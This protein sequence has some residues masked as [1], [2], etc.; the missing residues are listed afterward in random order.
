MSDSSTRMPL[1]AARGTTLT[2]KSWLTEAPLRMLMNNLD[3]E[4]AERPRR[5]RRLRRH[6]QGGAQLGVLRRD[7]RGAAQR[8][9]ADETLLI[10]SGKPVGVFRT[11]ADAPRVLIANSNLVPRWATWEHFQRARPQGPHDVRPDDGRLVDLHRQPGHR[12]GHLRD[13]RRGGPP[14]LRRRPRRALDPHRRP[15]RHGRR[16]AAGRH[17]GR[18]LDARRSSAAER[19]DDAPADAATSTSQAHD[20]DDALAIIARARQDAGGDLGRP[21]RQRRRAAA[22]AACAAA[23]A[24]IWS[25]TRRRPTTRSTAICRRGWTLAQWD[26]H[27]PARTLPRSPRAARAVDGARTCE[28]MLDFQAHG[29]AG[30]RLRQQHPPGRLRCG[31]E[32][33]LRLPRLRARLHPAAVLP[34][35]GPVPLGRALGRPG[36]H[37]QDRRQGEGALPATTRTCTAGSTWRASASSSRAC[38]RASA[39]WAWASAHR[40]GLAFNE[41]VARGELKA[42]IVIGRDHLDSGSVASPNRETEAMRDGSDAVADW[43]LLNALLNT[44]SGATWVSHPPRRRRRHGLLAA[45]RRGHR[46]RRHAEPRRAASS[47]CCGTT[48]PPA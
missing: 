30:L 35:H 45:R 17:H 20:L 15:G 6:R 19:I 31:R 29:H 37:L 14:A 11:H 23:C 12:A 1:R 38:R 8:S 10:Q 33:R 26:A 21:A 9:T 13:L 4:V 36:G 42:P 32:E 47:G 18:R 24:P 44:A 5:S 34:R 46:L 3:P 28:A 41:M 27:A 2:A 16:A 48:R 39:G 25:P 22:R 40:A 7:R 43:P